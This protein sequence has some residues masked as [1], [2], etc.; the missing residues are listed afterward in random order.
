MG[1]EEDDSLMERRKLDQHQV[2][3]IKPGEE[4]E[5][6]VDK[7]AW[8]VSSIEN[9]SMNELK[10]NSKLHGCVCVRF[11]LGRVQCMTQSTGSA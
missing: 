8:M 1:G 9:Y 6:L 7:S 5:V 10:F 3:G 11:R 4:D 2:S